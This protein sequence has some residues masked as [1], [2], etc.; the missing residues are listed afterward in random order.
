MSSTDALGDCDVLPICP[1]LA[2]SN[3]NV[4]SPKGLNFSRKYTHAGIDPL[5]MPE[6]RTRDSVI[7]N[8]AKRS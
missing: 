6:Y 2:K 3:Q 8:P 5:D 7:A 4:E 1:Q